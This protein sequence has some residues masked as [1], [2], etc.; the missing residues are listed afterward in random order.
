MAWY[1]VKVYN[2]FFN[3]SSDMFGTY[4]QLACMC[5]SYPPSFI[6]TIELKIA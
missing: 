5:R 2:G 6:W 4:E 3:T 1:T